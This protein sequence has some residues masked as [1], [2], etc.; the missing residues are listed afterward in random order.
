MTNQV[1]WWKQF[2]T[3][4]KNVLLHAAEEE[5]LLFPQVK[6]SLTQDERLELGSN[7]RAFKRAAAAAGKP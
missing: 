5:R 6:K 1:I 4:R 7:M 3:L 2:K